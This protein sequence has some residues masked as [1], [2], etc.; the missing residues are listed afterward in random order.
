M[1]VKKE[2]VV[3]LAAW[4]VKP[5]LVCIL[6]RLITTMLLSHIF[7]TDKKTPAGIKV[8]QGSGCS[9]VLTTRSFVITVSCDCLYF[10]ALACVIMSTCVG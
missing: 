4:C 6:E 3:Q 1:T 7:L 5:R 10:I 8:L 2:I 9:I